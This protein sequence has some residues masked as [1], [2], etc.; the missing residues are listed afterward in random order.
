MR[1]TL[2]AISVMTAATASRQGKGLFATRDFKAG[3]AIFQERPLVCCQF[4]WNAA[5]GY[6]A[7]VFCMK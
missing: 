6:L 2:F 3:D 7:C 1:C 5:Y 4:L